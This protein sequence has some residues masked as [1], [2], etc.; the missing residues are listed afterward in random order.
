MNKEDKKIMDML[1]KDKGN[2]YIIY[3]D[4]DAVFVMDKETT[5]DVHTF[6]NYG[7]EFVVDLMKYMGLD[8]EAV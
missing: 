1:T 6:Y 8:C 5:E 2:K 3:V 4:N 7:W